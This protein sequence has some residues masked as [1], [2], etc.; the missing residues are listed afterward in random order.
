LASGV[1]GDPVV[2]RDFAGGLQVFAPRAD[3]SVLIVRQAPGAR[4]WSSKRALVRPAAGAGAI[5]HI[6]VLRNGAG[7]LEAFAA[8]TDGSIF[9]SVQTQGSGWNR[10]SQIGW[11]SNAMAAVLRSDR[12]VQVLALKGGDL[13]TTVREG[14]TW[15]PWI[16]LGRDLSGGIAT[17]FGADGSLMVLSEDNQ[18]SLLLRSGDPREFDRGFG[19][20]LASEFVDLQA[21]A[22]TALPGLP[23]IGDLGHRRGPF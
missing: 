12:R 11:G 5:E 17:S 1:A 10:W 8:T 21:Q 15:S 23:Q 3:G 22:W 13:L 2:A 4:S 9:S 16:R 18:G 20:R 6:S 14:K 19:G 7:K